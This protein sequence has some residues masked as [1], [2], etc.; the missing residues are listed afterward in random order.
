VATNSDTHHPHS[1]AVVDVCGARTMVRSRSG[2]RELGHEENG[3]VGEEYPSNRMG[4]RR[5]TWA[6]GTAEPRQ[7]QLAV[8][9]PRYK[10]TVC[11]SDLLFLSHWI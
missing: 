6:D 7:S 5:I 4:K 2:T 1:T 3:P 11:A 8:S 9:I 10:N